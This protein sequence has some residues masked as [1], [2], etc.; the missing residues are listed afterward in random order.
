[1]IIYNKKD[2]KSEKHPDGIWI[3]A[4]NKEIDALLEAMKDLYQ[5]D[6]LTEQP[7]L[8]NERQIGLLNQAKQDML[9]AK[10]AMEQGVEPDLVEID[11]QAA[12]DHLK[13]ILGE[14]HRE[15]LLDTLFS[16]FCLGK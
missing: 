6:V 3:S 4:Q 11:I 8:S 14:V 1:M 13:E 15:D 2:V 16:K 10:E 7:L 9:Q 5:Q 12:H